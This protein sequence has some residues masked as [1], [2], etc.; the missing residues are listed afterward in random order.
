MCCCCCCCC[1]QLSVQTRRLGSAHKRT[2]TYPD[3]TH[4]DF[5]WDRSGKVPSDLLTVL[6]QYSPGM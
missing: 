6:Q 4:M 5:V 1:C 3:Y 2:I